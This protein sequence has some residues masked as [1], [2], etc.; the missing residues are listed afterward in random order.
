M[1][2]Q[3]NQEANSGI[4][5]GSSLCLQTRFESNPWITKDAMSDSSSGLH[6]GCTNWII[7][8]IIKIKHPE[9]QSISWLNFVRKIIINLWDFYILLFAC[10]DV[11]MWVEFSWHAFE[12]NFIHISNSGEWISD[13]LLKGGWVLFCLST[14]I[15]Y[16]NIIFSK[17]WLMTA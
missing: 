4:L 8:V 14:R 3:Q 7:L 11:F 15:T 16:N 10:I 1:L 5:P 17:L 2:V 6:R 12:L 13:S 9:K